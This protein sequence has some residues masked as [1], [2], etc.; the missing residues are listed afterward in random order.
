MTFIKT[1]P[2]LIADD[3]PMLLKGLYDELHERGFNV[4]AQASNGEEAL[5]KLREHRPKLA[6]LDIDMPFLT[7]FEVVKQAKEEKL[8]TKFIILSFHKEKEYVAQAKTLGIDGY[9][10]KEDT[11]QDIEKCMEAVLEDRP[12][13]SRSFQPEALEDVNTGVEKLQLLTPS[14]VKILKMVAAHKT[15]TE[16]SEILGVSSR[17]VEKHR[18]NIITKLDIASGT[19]SLLNWT[20]GNKKS[21]GAL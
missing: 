21:I 11:F 8:G 19:N 3:H 9:L 10:L 5:A 13:F 17:T 2:I 12:F 14:E 6:L 15:T 7:G 4:V 1:I 16:I 18:S 20:I